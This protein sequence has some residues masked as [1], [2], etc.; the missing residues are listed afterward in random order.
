MKKHSNGNIYSRNYNIGLS[1]LVINQLINNPIYISH[2][3]HQSGKTSRAKMTRYK[4]LLVL[5]LVTMLMVVAK[6]SE[7][8]GET[9]CAQF[10][11]QLF[12]FWKDYQQTI[13][14]RRLLKKADGLI[15]A[16]LTNNSLFLMIHSLFFSSKG[17]MKAR[18]TG[19]SPF[20]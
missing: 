5:M 12:W 10:S 20:I 2:E 4:L 1:N 11:F 8:E 14:T 15:F 6:A 17:H 9:Q 16:T 18:H 3:G 19:K 7:D 13:R